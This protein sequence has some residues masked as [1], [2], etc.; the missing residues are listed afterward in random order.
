M[1]SYDPVCMANVPDEGALA[2]PR[3]LMISLAGGSFNSFS[4]FGYRNLTPLDQRIMR[5]VVSS[6]GEETRR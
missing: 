4:A 2:A 1:R 3:T 5:F 6:G